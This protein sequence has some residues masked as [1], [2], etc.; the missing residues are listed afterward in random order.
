MRKFL[1]HILSLLMF[2][3]P[4]G[5]PAFAGEGRHVAPIRAF[6]ESN[7]RPWLADPA[8]IAALKVQNAAH[9]RLLPGDIEAL[10]T[11]WRTEVADGHYKLINK[12]LSDPISAMLLAKQGQF[13]G[14]V[15]EIILMDAYGLNAAQSSVTSDYWQGDEQKFQKSFGDGKDAFFISD[16]EKDLSTQMLQSHACL[17]IVDETG[18]PIGAIA[19]GIDLNFL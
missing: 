3:L 16:P 12:L 13:S 19:V 10:D 8:I 4:A 11:E 14:A 6:V 9:A 18:T 5:N 2:A 17:T 7:V 15:T 1:P